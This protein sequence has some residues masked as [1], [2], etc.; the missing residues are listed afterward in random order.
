MRA[1]VIPPPRA[2]ES[3]SS[4]PTMPRSHRSQTPRC[5]ETATLAGAGDAT[6]FSTR[7]RFPRPPLPPPPVLLLRPPISPSA[8]PPCPPVHPRRPSA[9]P[10]RPSVRRRQ[11]TQQLNKES[12]AQAASR[13]S[14]RTSAPP[15]PGVP[16]PRPTRPVRP[17]V[18]PSVRQPRPPR[19][20]AGR[21]YWRPR[22]TGL[23]SSFSLRRV[24][25]LCWRPGQPGLASSFSLR[26]AGWL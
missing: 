26:R 16:P 3:A 13:P 14:V 12:P 11:K 18:R 4:F 8:R 19:P 2:K 10:V 15:R 1:R 7:S 23:T 6:C 22:W 24:G 25:W 21:L 5:V 17:S 9:P 20:S